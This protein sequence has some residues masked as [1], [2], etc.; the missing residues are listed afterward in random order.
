[1]KK[2][3]GLIAMMALLIS[4]ATNAAEIIIQPTDENGAIIEET[5]PTYDVDNFTL[6]DAIALALYQNKSIKSADI[7]F[8]K[9]NT[10][11]GQARA[12]MGTKL[13]FNGTQT[14]LGY[15]TVM[16]ATGMEVTKKDNQSLMFELSQPLYIG[17]KDKAAVKSARLGR[18]IASSTK[19]LTRQNIIM[20]ASMNYY[21]WLFARAVAHV[22]QEDL[23]LAQ[24]HYDLVKKNYEAEQTS[25][26][27]LLRAEVRLSESK[28]EFIDRQNKARLAKLELLKFL[29]LPMDT[30]LETKED[31]SIIEYEADVEKD[32]I[33]ALEERED[34]KMK[35]KAQE[36]AKQALVSA[37]GERQ[38]TL[39]IFAKGGQE[40][41]SSR[42]SGAFKRDETWTAGV[43]LQIPIIDANLAKHKI[44]EANTQ[45][46]NANNDYEDSL[47]QAKLEIQQEALSL[48]SSAEIVAAQKENI[49]QAEETVRLAKVR[50]E[51]GLFTQVDLFDAENAWANTKLLYYKAV[52]G[53]HQARLSYQLAIGK[54]GRKL[55][56][57][58]Q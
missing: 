40:D 8:D 11:V 19:V 36:I 5:A 51:N 57:K 48:H 55:I 46:E 21:S 53:H 4:S 6:N 1:M 43:S 52:L 17:N 39:A 3:L 32:I 14:R 23:N 44:S 45:I 27:E 7:A 47:E 13:N 18:D 42:Y 33:T 29:S 50:Y 34:L 54:L 2:T 25:K 22:G 31:L 58:E 10:V 38:P 49:K 30:N 26:Y 24:A 56:S 28:S 12:A 35:R 41:P 37:K 9:A 15:N 20:G 16:A